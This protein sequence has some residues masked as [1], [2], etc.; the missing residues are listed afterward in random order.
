MH[1]SG[2]RV[3]S[4]GEDPNKPSKISAKREVELQTK[5]Y[6]LEENNME[7][8]KIN[9][10]TNLLPGTLLQVLLK[11]GI[12]QSGDN[13]TILLDTEKILVDENGQYYFQFTNLTSSFLP[14]YY[15]LSVYI[16]QDQVKDALLAVGFSEES[17]EKTSSYCIL[18][19]LSM[20][21]SERR[22]KA[23]TSLT[24][25]LKQIPR[26][27][28]E[29]LSKADIIEKIKQGNSEIEEGLK[30]FFGLNKTRK[31]ILLD[32]SNDW[33]KWEKE[34]ILLMAE[35]SRQCK[36]EKVFLAASSDM[37]EAMDHLKSLHKQY[38]LLAFDEKDNLKEGLTTEYTIEQIKLFHFGENE[39]NAFEK[40]ITVKI[41]HDIIG[42]VENLVA[43][44][45][46]YS[47]KTSGATE[48]WV[49]YK[50]LL[51]GYLGSLKQ[52]MV[53]YK[54]GNLFVEKPDKNDR[55]SQCIILFDLMGGL[56]DK[57][58]LLMMDHDNKKVKGEIN[59]FI[60]VINR[61]S[62]ELLIR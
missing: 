37:L 7:I 44:Y 15:E 8:I 31:D 21:L 48:A 49:N 22:Q 32:L 9:G 40:E 53:A 61:K 18:N 52:E 27:K 13:S 45:Q 11:G 30:K 14:E 51:K 26:M 36:G 43:T 4:Q 50:I 62:M 24:N 35:L 17:I 55:Y 38:R 42:R 58:D 3:Y 10:K 16:F 47:G 29:L 59:D 34:W 20:Q 12:W 57:F 23:A 2:D 5:G 19:V 54:K 60:N 6:W 25:V 39:I 33:K 56:I 46:N 41:I 1:I 28:D